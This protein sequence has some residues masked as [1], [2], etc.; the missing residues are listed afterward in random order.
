MKKF[1]KG[2]TLVELMIVVAIIGILSAV[3]IPNFMKFQAKSRQSEAKTN[4]KG[5]HTSMVSFF[6]EKNKYPDTLTKAGF[7]T[8]G[9]NIYSYSLLAEDGDDVAIK[10]ATAGDMVTCGGGVTFEDPVPENCTFIAIASGNVD[11]DDFKDGWA[12]NSHGCL[13]NSPIE[14][15]DEGSKCAAAIDKEDGNDVII[16]EE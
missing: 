11:S 1:A 4:L 16:D 10:S 7:K 3:A 2:F 8:E 12:I 6:A 15:S 13:A 14:N 9:N 5:F